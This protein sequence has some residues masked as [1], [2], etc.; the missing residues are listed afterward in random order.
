MAKS[1]PSLPVIAAVYA[2]ISSDPDHTSLGVTRQTKDC[3]ALAKRKGWTVGEVFTDNDVSAT[4][5]KPR[6]QYDRMMTALAS[7]G[8]GALVVWDVDRLT[9]TPRELEDVVDL[10]ERHGVALASV[11]GEIDLA[12]PQ[13]RLTARIKGNVAKHESEQLGRRVKAKMAERAQ[14]GK[15]HG[16]TPFGWRREQVYDDQGHRLGSRD[17]LHPEQAEIVQQAAQAL[18]A[19]DS[20]RSITA[21]LNARGVL[22]LDGNPWATT[23]LRALLLRERNAALRVHHGQVI[24][25]GDWEPIYD[26]DTHQRIQ[27]LLN[28]PARRSSPPSSAIKYLLSGLATCSVCDGPM[29]VLTAGKDGR[30]TD[31]YVCHRGYH[32]RRVRPELDALIISLVTAR[33]A[34]PAAAAALA[35]SDDGQAAEALE[36]AAAV[37]ARMDLAA[38]AY[39]AGNID[40]AQLIRITGKLRPEL[41]RWQQ[42]ARATAPA[43]DLL[44]LATP[45]IA[46]RW[47][48][49]PLARRR[50]VIDLLLTIT[51]LPATRIGGHHGF[52]P[53]S[54]RVT[55]KSM[56]QPGLGTRLPKPGQARTTALWQP[57]QASRPPRGE[58][59]DAELR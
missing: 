55:W 25:A 46:Q 40:G 9:R 23:T 38:D 35:R 7:G 43:P 47:D 48:A 20:L 37:R 29:R 57:P 5:G 21:G 53:N 22:S 36:H 6:P 2:R 1:T 31:S 8:F 14:A 15:P 49:L 30:K 17:M 11:G 16:R 39:A 59:S 52:D 50:A 26:Q 58:R 45:D 12:T 27:A 4:S 32:V 28:D 54:V 33:L 18:L 56:W 51:V 13:G 34:L 19:G 44:D 42:L 41:D 3:L 10:A 24:G